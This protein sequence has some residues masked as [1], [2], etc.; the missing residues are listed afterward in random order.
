MQGYRAREQVCAVVLPGYA[1]RPRELSW[2][3]RYAWRRVG[4]ADFDGAHE[5]GVWLASR[6]AD[7]VEQLVHAVHEVNVGGARR[8]VEGARAW[9]ESACCVA[10]GVGLA[11]VGLDFD[12]AGYFL[13]PV[14][15]GNAVRA[16]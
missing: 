8:T 13:T 14:G 1:E 11:E 3:S 6:L 16:K 15:A 9:R 4:P 5:H 10:G 12:Y 2:A 7:D